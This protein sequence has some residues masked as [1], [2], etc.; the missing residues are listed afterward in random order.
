MNMQ[1]VTGS[2]YSHPVTRRKLPAPFSRP[3]INAG[4]APVK[5]FW[6]EVSVLAVK[7]G[8]TV[9]GF[10]VVEDVVEFINMPMEETQDMREWR[11]RVYNVVGEYRDFPGH[12]RVHA[13]TA[14]D[15][16]E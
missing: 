10:G 9:A 15:T 3:S 11:I 16:N 12:E 14:E 4:G 1:G 7:K 8:D 2:P 5:R 6:K 13:F